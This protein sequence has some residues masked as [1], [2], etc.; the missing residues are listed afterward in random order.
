MLE[1][2][3]FFFLHNIL[4]SHRI[5]QVS[6]LYLY[7]FQS[8]QSPIEVNLKYYSPKYDCYKIFLHAILHCSFKTTMIEEFFLKFTDIMQFWKSQTLLFQLAKFIC[9]LRTGF[10][11]KSL[12][13]V[14]PL[15]PLDS[16]SSLSSVCSSLFLFPL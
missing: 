16:F 12:P 9:A 7:I 15:Y 11:V 5:N 10:P 13:A 1:I 2:S 3:F 14:S 6:F 4:L 8:P